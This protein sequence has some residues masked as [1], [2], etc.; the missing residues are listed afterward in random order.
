MS[1]I[2]AFDAAVAAHAAG[3]CQLVYEPW[4]VVKAALGDD[5]DI[6]DVGPAQAMLVRNQLGRFLVVRGTQVTSGWSWA[7]IVSNMELKMVPWAWDS[8][9]HQGYAE[10]C[11]LLLDGVTD[12]LRVSAP[13]IYL[14]GHSL[15]GAVA[16]LLASILP[17]AA[18]YSFGAPK[19]GDARL[20]RL[21]VGRTQLFRVV[22]CADIAPKY[23]VI[24]GDYVHH[25]PYLRLGR[26][27]EM[28]EDSWSPSDDVPV[29][30]VLGV[31]DHRVSEYGSKLRGA[32]L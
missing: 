24:L 25:P 13:P 23:P 28:S 31:F 3:L 17:C 27:G 16:T 26:G 32:Q 15:G 14:T 11:R 5:V 20:S 29:P 18:V 9:A 10:Q 6:I 30:L 1:L 12:L 19:V 2:G 21:I 22:H 7:D 8:R 4:A